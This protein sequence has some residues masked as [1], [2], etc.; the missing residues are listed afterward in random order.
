MKEYTIQARPREIEAGF[1]R[2]QWRKGMQVDSS[3]VSLEVSPRENLRKCGGMNARKLDSISG[4]R[5]RWRAVRLA[6]PI[7]TKRRIWLQEKI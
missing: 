3:G 2:G 7:E 1:E 6:Q 4:V 5:V